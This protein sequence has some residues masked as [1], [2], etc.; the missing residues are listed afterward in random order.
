MLRMEPPLELDVSVKALLKTAFFPDNTS[1]KSASFSVV[2]ENHPADVFFCVRTAWDAF[3]SAQKFPAGSEI[4]M[5]GINIPHMKE[6]VEAHGLTART[7][8]ICPNTLLPGLDDFKNGYTSRTV[9]VLCAH[10][11]GTWSALTEL[12][13]WCRSKNIFLV[14]DCAQSFMGQDFTGTK[15]ATATFF[16]FGTIKRS[17]CLGG[18]VALVREPELRTKILSIESSYPRQKHSQ[19]KKKARKTLLLKTLTLPRVYGVFV[20]TLRHLHIDHEEF[21]RNSVRG[22]PS[23]QVPFVF[24]MRPSHEL[25]KLV[26]KTWQKSSSFMWTERMTRIMEAAA[27]AGI[28]RD[29]IPGNDAH[30]HTFWLLPVLCGNPKGVVE[31]LRNEG[32]DA[33]RGLSSMKDLSDNPD[34]ASAKILANLV[35]LPVSQRKIFP[36]TKARAAL[37]IEST[38]ASHL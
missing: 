10:L 28:P 30:F 15:T 24:R 1:T 27:S 22:F 20:R 17:T 7:L 31:T 23:A 21:I 14:E 25:S 8:D 16:S 11:F 12:A 32:L 34:S 29:R 37:E 2:G 35:F 5:S 38:S 4:L 33:T 18:A 36:F 26:Q 19:V 3:L 6:I 9:G 13:T